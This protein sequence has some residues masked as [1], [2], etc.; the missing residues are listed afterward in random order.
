SRGKE[1][2]G[3]TMTEA[4]WLAATD[5]MEML[6]LFRD[7]GVSRK[8]RLYTCACC[9][10]CDWLMSVPAA[11][12]AVAAAER[13]AE[14]NGTGTEVSA[15]M[16][17]LD[18]TIPA[19]QAGSRGAIRLGLCSVDTFNASVYTTAWFNVDDDPVLERWCVD[20]LRDIFGNPFRPVKVDPSWLTS[21]VI[22]LAE[23][24]Y[25]ERAFD[26]LPILADALQA[27]GCDNADVLSHCRGE[28]PHV[29]GCWVVDLLTGR[30]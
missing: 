7:G 9:R 19:D 24:I 16:S 5:T 11:R 30:S 21:I 17:E 1:L 13:W 2:R 27:A 6:E 12:R 22:A 25:A 8:L 23:G 3:E 26:R 10:A 14:G 28:G 29:R 4:E 15:H 18:E 20:Q